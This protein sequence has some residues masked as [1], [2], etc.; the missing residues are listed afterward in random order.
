MA[1]KFVRVTDKRTGHRYS[2][3]ETAVDESQHNVLKQ[4][5]VDSDGRPLPPEY[6]TSKSATSSEKGS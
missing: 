4:D 2:I 1:E 6:A 5:A 3:A